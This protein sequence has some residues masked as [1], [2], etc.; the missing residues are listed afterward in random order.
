MANARSSSVS[1]WTAQSRKSWKITTLFR[2]RVGD[3]EQATVLPATSLC[4]PRLQVSGESMKISEKRSP[5]RVIESLDC[6]TGA[7]L[8]QNYVLRVPSVLHEQVRYRCP[9]IRNGMKYSITN[10]GNLPVS[11]A[12]PGMEKRK[13]APR[14]AQ[15][16]KS[17]K[18]PDLTEMD[19]GQNKIKK[20][21]ESP[22]SKLVPHS[23]SRIV[24]NS[25]QDTPG[26]NP[27]TPKVTSRSNVCE[28]MN[29]TVWTITSSNTLTLNV[30]LPKE[31]NNSS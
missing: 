10:S 28:P 24:C 17:T 8:Q 30:Y 4:Q 25:D 18:V 2:S 7:T 1:T 31:I 14:T 5:S 23:G 6:S 3:T 22:N 9:T 12:C 19:E 27:L 29:D 16:L 26:F 21:V 13:H 11:P 20:T 15:V